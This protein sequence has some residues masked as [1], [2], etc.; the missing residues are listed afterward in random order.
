VT[1][2]W[3]C[4]S[5]QL[6]APDKR[7]FEDL[8]RE[9]AGGSKEASVTAAWLGYQQGTGGDAGRK[10][11][12]KLKELG[13][14]RVRDGTKKGSY[15]VSMLDPFAVVK[16][17]GPPDPNLR[18]EFARDDQA[19]CEPGGEDATGELRVI[20]PESSSACSSSQALP[21]GPPDT[22]PGVSRQGRRTIVTDDPPEDR[23][24]D[25]DDRPDLVT[26]LNFSASASPSTSH[27]SHLPSPPE[28]CAPASA[29]DPD[30]ARRRSSGGSS[31]SDQDSRDQDELLRT[32]RQRRAEMADDRP[33]ALDGGASVGL[34]AI[35]QAKLEAAMS[36]QAREQRVHE[37]VGIQ[38]RRVRD[39]SMM[40]APCVRLAWAIVEGQVKERSMYEALDHLDE[41]DAKHELLKPR[42]SYYNGC[43][44]R[45]LTRGGADVGPPNPPKPR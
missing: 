16:A 28:K 31:A 35:V 11:I 24:H 41:L 10:R 45:L 42:S 20:R 30:E 38:L 27:F 26:S 23:R 43:I 29:R 18:F 4:T 37:L 17:L 1:Y 15:W 39:R 14:I 19:T 7:A 5:D 44:K 12:K 32:F 6:T 33:T 21:M 36:P 3:R 25:P 40:R 9:T 34:G 13:F 8:W 22:D 2:V